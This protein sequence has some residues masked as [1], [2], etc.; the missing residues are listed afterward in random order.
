MI[1]NNSNHTAGFVH[2][3]C[4]VYAGQRL[5]DVGVTNIVNLEP[6]ISTPGKTEPIH[7]IPGLTPDRAECD[8][9]AI[10]E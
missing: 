2:I 5:I 3:R 6:G 1:R 10:G 7:D 9:Q 4:E 8:A